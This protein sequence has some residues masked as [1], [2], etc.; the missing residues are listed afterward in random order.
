MWT[1]SKERKQHSVLTVLSFSGTKL[2]T[3]FQYLNKIAP[4][5]HGNG[6]KNYTSTSIRVNIF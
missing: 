3:E 2:K 6:R 1:F 5:D 4:E